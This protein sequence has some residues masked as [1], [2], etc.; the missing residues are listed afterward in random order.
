MAFYSK[1]S[2]IVIKVLLV[3]A[4]VALMGMMVII[5]GNSLGRA[6]FKVPI[7]GTIEIAGLA[8]VIVVA[9]AVG[10]AEREQSNIVVDVVANRFTPR[11]KALADAFTL[12]L[13]VGAVAFLLWAIF[14]DALH[15]LTMRE[16]TL[17]TGVLT[18]PFKFT[19]AIGAI[20]L[21]LFLLQ[22]MIEAFRRVGKR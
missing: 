6:L 17:T 7:F 15:S 14:K 1:L 3:V 22:H 5:V 8:G 9:V 10:F 2:H 4:G 12:L 19:W 21:C 11:I 20:I 13:S 16:I 18:T